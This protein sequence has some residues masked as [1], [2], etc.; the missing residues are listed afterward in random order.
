MPTSHFMQLG[1]IVEAMVTLNPRAILDI[2]VGF[3]K[4]GVLAREYLDVSDGRDAYRDWKRRIDGVEAFGEYLTP[5][6]DFI[7]DE[8]FIGNA[9]AVVPGLARRYDLVLLVDVIEHLTKEE[10]VK[11]L[12][13]C[14]AVS[15][16]VLISTPS[17]FIEQHE[18]FGNVHEVHKSHWK[19]S[20]FAAIAPMCALPN[21][22]EISLVCVIG[23]DV[24]TVRRGMRGWRR[25]LK[26]ALPFILKPYRALKS[27]FHRHHH[28]S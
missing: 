19:A 17:D 10:G 16:N 18:H 8:V 11:L 1:T 3:G 7:Y 6:H 14:L 22:D 9:T 4:Y 13:D 27:R 26:A 2:G 20:D 28:D 24:E 25:R 23:S 21:P 12:R 15:R 5:L